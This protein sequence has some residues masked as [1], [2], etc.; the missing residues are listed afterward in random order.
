MWL[1]SVESV[2][3]TL[4]ARELLSVHRH[5]CA[6]VAMRFNAMGYVPNGDGRVD[7]SS[8]RRDCE[9]EGVG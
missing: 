3:A 4:G 5:R 9:G 8:R 1:G 2:Q 6:G 7:R